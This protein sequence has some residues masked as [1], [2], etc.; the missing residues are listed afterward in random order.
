[1]SESKLQPAAAALP[2]PGDLLNAL[3]DIKGTVQIS[4]QA[5]Y[6]IMNT[7]TL[8]EHPEEAAETLQA[9]EGALTLT[10]AAIERL[11]EQLDAM[12][13]VWPTEAEEV[14]HG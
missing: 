11:Y 5:V 1:M 6:N 8:R 4:R 2:E 13:M 7:V 14:A 12:C 3:L 9:A 10:E